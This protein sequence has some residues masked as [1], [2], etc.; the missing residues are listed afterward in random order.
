[1]KGVLDPICSKKHRFKTSQ[2]NKQIKNLE[3]LSSKNWI[4]WFKV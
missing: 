1:M 4:A 3:T 2:V